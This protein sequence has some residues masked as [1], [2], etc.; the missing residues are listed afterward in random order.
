MPGHGVRSRHDDVRPLLAAYGRAVA[1]PDRSVRMRA[2]REWSRWEDTLIGSESGAGAYS[3][4][5]DDALVALVR[6]C[7][8]YFSHDAFL[9][10]AVLRDAGKLAGI[11][12]TLVHGRLDLSGPADTAYELAQ[13]WPD[14]EL[15][16]VDDAGHTGG[17]AF[18][19]A[20]RRALVG[21]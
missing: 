3:D 8:H 19:E 13:R 16:I 18:A 9:D 17:P 2:A 14:A 12:G 10:D 20:I 4:R 21:E 11:P 1:D 5:P 7:A 6:I 15:V